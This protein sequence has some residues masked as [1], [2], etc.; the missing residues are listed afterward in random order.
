MEI[1][2][3]ESCTVFPLPPKLL[4]NLIGGLPLSLALF[5]TTLG[6]VKLEKAEPTLVLCYL[7][8]ELEDQIEDLFMFHFNG[9]RQMPLL[10]S[11][12]KSEA[13]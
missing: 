3:T 1:W 5:Q 8:R 10:F 9:T 12:A 11:S 7:Q 4:E 13:R 2:C 6:K